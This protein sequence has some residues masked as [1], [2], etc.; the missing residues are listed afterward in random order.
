M[1][2][3]ILLMGSST[4]VYTYIGGMK[5]VVWTD[6]VQ[7]FIYLA[8]AFVALGLLIAKIPGGWDELVARGAAAGK[9]QFFDFRLDPSR[10]FTFWAGLVG[11]M[12][13]NTATHGADQLMV[14]RYLSARSQRQA[15]GALIVSGFV[16]LAQFALFLLIGVALFAFYQDHPPDRPLAR[17]SEF[18]Y[19]IARYMPVGILGLV[20]A[21][22]FSAAMSTLSSSLNSS[23]AT[24][25]NDL[26]KPLAPAAPEASLLAWSRALTVVWGVAQIGV[27]L[28]ASLYLDANV[29]NTALAIASFVTGIVLGLFLLALLSPRVGQ[30][31]ALIGLV[32]GLAVVSY[33]KFG[34]LLKDAGLYP[35]PGAIA[36]PWFA[37]I[38]SSTV[39]LVGLL[40]SLLLPTKIEHKTLL[41][42]LS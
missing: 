14:Q 40:A 12:V 5:A 16:V 9:F 28:C 21:A 19:F 6:V 2:V 25:V 26:I 20:V 33:V 38:G 42:D 32:A 8:G 10:E 13:L 41:G 37:L 4:L 29:V 23:A 31:A 30:S 17:D 7:F 3:A 15:A 18:A 39:V 11:G 27:A 22:I 1:P 36:W 24:T 35:F 34:P